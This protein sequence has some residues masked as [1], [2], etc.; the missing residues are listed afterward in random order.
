MISDDSARRL[1]DKATRGGALSG[2]EREALEEWT[3]AQDE[4]EAK[5]LSPKS[6]Q[7]SLAEL[8]SQVESA[9]EQVEAAT[10][11]IRRLFSE[12]DSLRNE[13][14]ALCKRLEIRAVSLSA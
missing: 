11:V 1:H 7:P 4:A 6:L 5:L 10:G 3:S 8:R 12:N 14:A 13:N 2:K 9:L